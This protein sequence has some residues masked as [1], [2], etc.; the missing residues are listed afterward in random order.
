MS[1]DTSNAPDGD[2]E[3]A[4]SDDGG[5]DV[6]TLKARIARLERE[7]KQAYEKR[8]KKSK[9]LE[10][11]EAKLAEYEKREREAAEAQARKDKD[12]AKLEKMA[13]EEKAALATELEQLK[14][15]I[16]EAE[17][18]KRAS[19]LLDAIMAQGG[20][21]AEAKTLVEGFLLREERNGED[22][23]PSEQ[24]E[25][26]AKAFLKKLRTSAPLLFKPT[27]LG[28]NGT[29]GTMQGAEGATDADLQRAI[30]SLNRGK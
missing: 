20:L 11:R 28:P 13:A 10:E 15:Q 9:A 27:S 5:E 30:D 29:P 8:D 17:K 18:A 7:A 12:Y 22:I 4:D 2:A 25:A 23:A 1:E 3:D 16:A 26:R 21:Q 24:V 6:E 19:S 14:G